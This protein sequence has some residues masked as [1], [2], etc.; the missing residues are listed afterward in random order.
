MVNL[1]HILTV[2]DLIVEYMMAKINNGYEVFFTISE[3]MELLHILNQQS[4]S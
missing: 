3:F 4:R 2:D 1:D